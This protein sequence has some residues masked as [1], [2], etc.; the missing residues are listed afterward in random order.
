MSLTCPN[1]HEAELLTGVK[2]TD[3]ASASAAIA[4]LRALGANDVIITLGE[5]GSVVARREDAAPT[6]V[7]PHKV[8]AVDSTG[9]GDCFVG[10]LAFFLAR[11]LPLMEATRRANV[12]AALSVTR[13]G[14][15]SS[16]LP[17]AEL[18]PALFNG[19]PDG[20]SKL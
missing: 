12:I 14:T 2:V 5:N 8:K 7:P 6:L 17:R 11:G 18:P 16:Y 13:K 15:Q 1:E 9:A 20:R 19:I 3:V 4:A 10:S